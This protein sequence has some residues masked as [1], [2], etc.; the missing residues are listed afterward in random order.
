MLS[1][2]GS[3]RNWN[4]PQGSLYPPQRACRNPTNIRSACI[5]FFRLLAFLLVLQPS[6]LP[7]QDIDLKRMVVYR[8]KCHLQLIEGFFPCDGK[9]FY[10]LL[11]NGRTLIAFTK[12][13]H[14]FTVVGGSDRQPNLENYYVSLDK[15][16]VD[17]NGKREAQDS[18]MEGECH[19]KMNKD[20]TKFYFIKCDI[21]NRAKGSMYNF[22][23]ENIS[24]FDRKEF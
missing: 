7:A 1:Q 2:N 20:A 17:K 21:Y 15:I 23:L 8:G 12:G 11:R 9:V 18:N 16:I 3:V 24:G 10:S 13:D 5:R 4:D 19:F 6:P 22:Y 14:M